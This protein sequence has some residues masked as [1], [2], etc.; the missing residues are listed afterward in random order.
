M[1]SRDHLA[2]ALNNLVQEQE[3][4]ERDTLALNEHEELADILGELLR[5]IYL[6]MRINDI[7]KKIQS[8]SKLDL[9]LL[10]EGIKIIE[11]ADP[12]TITIVQSEDKSVEIIPSDLINKLN[13]FI[14]KIKSKQHGLS[15]MEIL[16]QLEYVMDTCF[17]KLLTTFA[18]N[19]K[20][21]N[22]LIALVLNKVQDLSDD[23][24]ILLWGQIKI[25][26]K[27]EQNEGFYI[28]YSDIVAASFFSDQS[29]L[30]EIR[31]K[32]AE[33]IVRIKPLI[34]KRMY[35]EG[36]N[37]FPVGLPGVASILASPQNTSI[38]PITKLDTLLFRVFSQILA[39]YSSIIGHIPEVLS[40]LTTTIG[41]A[42]NSLILTGDA[43]RRYKER[44]QSKSNKKTVTD[45]YKLILLNIQRLID[46]SHS[47]TKEQSI[48]ESALLQYKLGQEVI[49]PARNSEFEKIKYSE[50]YL[51]KD[52]CKFLLERNI[53]SFGKN[54][55]KGQIDLYH[56]DVV[57]EE[58]IVEAKVYKDNKKLKL[59]NL[60]EN[61]VQLQSYMDQHV[62]PRG[63]LAIY[64]FTDEVILA[65]RKW[66]SGR[67]FIFCI[68]LCSS[69]P[70]NRQKSKQI[71]ESDKGII[72]LIETGG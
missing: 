50:S 44:L 13:A 57:G 68:N 18:L 12:K 54:F 35:E 71:V 15:P 67:I 3:L 34:T 36:Q 51:Q 43:Y 55:G 5:S 6:E 62:Q 58:F 11:G 25:G 26:F 1:K 64:N 52:L 40:E 47:S 56:K 59:K 48:V 16:I 23:E 32:C 63:I 4:F 42:T 24:I 27:N 21:F 28:P 14:D 31:K 46:Y 37:F 66:L 10:Q 7:E 65:P 17:E 69:T 61:L 33:F 72:D 70:S 22:K 60:N 19:D 49:T 53:L 29:Q 39:I 9:E 20:V 38:Q 45:K 2:Q 8:K 41:I 30:S